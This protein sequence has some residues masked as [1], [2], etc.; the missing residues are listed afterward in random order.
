M[1]FPPGRN[2]TKNEDISDQF[3]NNAYFSNQIIRAFSNKKNND[4]KEKK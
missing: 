2:F 4:K 1:P 3:F